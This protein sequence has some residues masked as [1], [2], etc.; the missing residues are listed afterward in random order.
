MKKYYI[1]FFVTIF[2]CQAHI[3]AQEIDLENLGGR[4][5]KV[6]KKNPF[7]I[8]G[9]I[10]ASSVFFN[11][12][13]NK[14]RSPFTYFL[15]G[16]INLGFYQ[17]SMPLSISLTNQGHN[18]NYQIPWNFNR[19]SLHPKYKWIRAHIGDVNMS[20]SPYTYNGLNFRGVGMELT[21]KIPL[22][23]AFMAG[24]L[25]KAIE[26]DGNLQT[27]PSF[28]RMGYGANVKW[29]KEKYKISLIGFYAKDNENSLKIIPKSKGVFPQ[30]NFVY[31]VD[32]SSF[33]HRNI[34]IYATYA[35][36]IF[37]NDLRA[38]SSSKK[39]EK[40]LIF[41][42]KNSHTDTFNA[43][44]AG[45]DLNLKNVTLGIKY[46]HID[47]EYKTLG[48][49]YFNND[50]ENIT[51]SSSFNMFDSKL[52]ISSNIGRQIDNLEQQKLKRTNR[53]IGSINANLKA[54]E[55]LIV[56]ANYSNFT[57]FTNQKLNQFENINKNPLLLQQPKDSISFKQIT[58]N[59]NF[60]VNYNISKRKNI[61]QNINFNYS[62]NDMVNKENDIVR[63][64]GISR[65]HNAFATYSTTFSKR[66][67]NMAISINYT[68]V[69]SNSQ[70]SNIWGPS[71]S[72]NKSF[73]KEKLKTSLGLSYNK[74]SSKLS[75][76]NMF[77]F[78]MGA[79]YSPWKK[80]LFSVNFVQMFRHMKQLEDKTNNEMVSNITYRYSF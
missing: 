52:M 55:N 31:S 29:E 58:Q 7:K 73:L 13:V 72:L 62:L 49:Y 68:N 27:I 40:N 14:S 10:S 12:N 48:A 71:F 56:S 69:Y 63:K 18:L 60:S 38:F 3:Q 30:E 51:V 2:I 5:K 42:G 77:N 41:S 4:I 67:L 57:M 66:K 43:Y 78:R 21:P 33:I 65:F 64:G 26:D 9:G 36:S 44:N 59:V 20:F 80:H 6:I 35:K 28:K 79:N 45:I 54:S 25:N 1:L 53:W 47:P 75:K 74:S 34:K 8:S 46:E 16:N 32:F 70:K 17:W 15:N 39:E 37:I 50:L 61:L 24:R 76:I 22:K 19:I 11:S 23:V